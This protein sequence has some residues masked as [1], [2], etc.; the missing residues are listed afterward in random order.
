MFPTTE[1]GDTGAAPYPAVRALPLLGIARS[2]PVENLSVRRGRRLANAWKA[3]HQRQGF[4]GG[5]LA[6]NYTK[7]LRSYYGFGRARSPCR[8]LAE[9]GT[10][11]NDADHAWLFANLEAS[12]KAHVDAIGAVFGHPVPEPEEE[13]VMHF[14]QFAGGRAVYTVHGDHLEW[15]MN[16]SHLEYLGMGRPIETAGPDSGLNHLPVR[17]NRGDGVIADIPRPEFEQRFN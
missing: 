2:Q 12:A 10:T 3:A 7:A 17:A 9:H 11:T 15:V 14:V 6:D 5:F 4:P 16:I 8:F 1:S 13:S